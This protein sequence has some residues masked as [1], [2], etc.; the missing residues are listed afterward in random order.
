MNNTTVPAYLLPDVLIGSVVVVAAV[1][2]GLR[3]VLGPRSRTFRILS[4]TLV[5]WFLAALVPTWLG[6]YQGTHSRVPTIQYGLLIPVLIGILLFWRWPTLRRVVDAVPQRWIVTVQAYR[7][8]GLIFLVLY[9]AGRMPVN[10]PGQ[11][12]SA[13]FIVGLLAPIVGLAYARGWRGSGSSVRAW[14][15]LGLTDL[16]VAVTTGF[17]SSPSPLQMLAFDRPNV[18]IG[19]FPLAMIPVFL[20]PLSVLLHLAS[21]QKLHHTA[22]NSISSTMKYGAI[23]TQ[24]MPLQVRNQR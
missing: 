2:I 24:G 17:L 13:M 15:F 12:V 3:L 11:L 22:K 7:V 9:A 14:N 18:L 5:A 10:L 16:V 1:I 8:E 4:V 20:V 19:A 21:L 23:K 6:F